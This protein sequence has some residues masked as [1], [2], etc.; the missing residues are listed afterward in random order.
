MVQLDGSRSYDKSGFP[1]EYG[2]SLLSAPPASWA[3]LS[4]PCSIRPT[5]EADLRGEYVVQLVVTSNNKESTSDIVVISTEN[6]QPV[7]VAGNDQTGSVGEEIHLDGGTSR[8]V[9]ADPLS[10]RWSLLSVPNGSSASLRGSEDARAHLVPDSPGTYLVQLIV[11]DGRTA[12]VPDTVTI[13]I[14]EADDH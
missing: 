4:P 3:I 9:D 10:Y 1:L 7:A 14:G 6:S 12:S 5:F 2:W 8:D 13:T 11:R